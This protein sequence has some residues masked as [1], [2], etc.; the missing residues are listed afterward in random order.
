[1]PWDFSM[2]NRQIQADQNAQEM[3]L[4]KQMFDTKLQ[5]GSGGGTTMQVYKML[6]QQYP[7]ADPMTLLRI[8]QNKVGTDLTVDME[9]GTVNPLAGAP[10]AR[11]QL[12]YGGQTGK[13]QSDLEYANPT[14]KAGK[15]GDLEA[16]AQ[17][18]YNKNAALASKMGGPLEEAEGILNQRKAS[19]SWAGAGWGKLKSSGFGVS[20]EQTQADS[21]LRLLGDTLAGNVPRF[22]GPQ[23]DADRK[24]YISMAGSLGDNTIPIDDRLANVKRMKNMRDRAGTPDWN[25][26]N[27]PPLPGQNPNQFDELNKALNEVKA[28]AVA[29]GDFVQ[30][31]ANPNLPKEGQTAT[32]RKTGKKII[33]RNGQW[34]PL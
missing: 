12:E 6:Q 4:K 32:N 34:V 27:P 13:N 3:A 25:P 31:N 19:G 15:L 18:T 9:T 28:P 11:G 17:A 10:Q 22:E 8:A 2:Y 16:E 23:S 20:D 21:E 14:K 5:T 26:N 24:Y 1:M 7:N 33:F 29:E 30:P